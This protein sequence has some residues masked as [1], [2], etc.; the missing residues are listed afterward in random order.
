M[1]A[2]AIKQAV[3]LGRQMKKVYVATAD[4]NGRPHLAVAGAITRESADRIGVDAW[5]CPGTVRNIEKNPNIS[6]V[7]WDPAADAGH[8]MVGAVEAVRETAMMDG[9]TPEMEGRPPLPQ[10]ERKL[11]IHVTETLA[12]SQAPHADETESENGHPRRAG[13]L[14]EREVDRP[15]GRAGRKPGAGRPEKTAS[16]PPAA[17]FSPR[18]RRTHRDGPPHPKEPDDETTG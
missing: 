1:H 12:F 11:I 14:G 13:R 2:E 18:W 4:D 9:H 10:A 6:V 15:G 17:P 16:K 5:F 8:Q 7:A 3:E